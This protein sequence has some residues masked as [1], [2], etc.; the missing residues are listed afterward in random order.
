VHAPKY[1]WSK[2]VAANHA[3]LAVC[4]RHHYVTRDDCNACAF[5][6]M[7]IWP[8]EK[9]YSF[10]Q[11]KQHRLLLQLCRPG[12]LLH[13]LTVLLPP[14]SV[15]WLY[16]CFGPT[17]YFSAQGQ[18]FYLSLPSS[19]KG[20]YATAHLVNEVCILTRW[21]VGKDSCKLFRDIVSIKIILRRLLF[22]FN[23]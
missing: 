21:S 4:L 19:T 5:S 13:P 9:F 14:I 1:S 17:T 7:I 11:L 16:T 23:I 15:V 3:T 12:Q 6:L 20:Y 18:H 8:G 2:I 22:S 10:Q